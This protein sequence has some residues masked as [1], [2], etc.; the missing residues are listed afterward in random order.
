M[1]L[2]RLLIDVFLTTSIQRHDMV[3]RRRNVKTA[4]IN[5]STTW[6]VYWDVQGIFNKRKGALR[7]LGIP[8]YNSQN[9]LSS[10]RYVVSFFSKQYNRL[11][12]AFSTFKSN[13]SPLVSVNPSLEWL[14]EVM[15]KITGWSTKKY[16][17][18]VLNER[19]SYRIAK[20]NRTITIVKAIEQ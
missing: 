11:M 7:H 14:A 19:W 6:S 1:S 18:I 17:R 3:E 12:G 8:D 5:V 4:V 16:S 13:V 9:I 2:E 10:F 20:S 15:C